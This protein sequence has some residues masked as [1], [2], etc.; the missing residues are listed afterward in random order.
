[1]VLSSVFETGVGLLNSLALG[2]AL[3]EM[4]RA[5]GFD[6]LHFSD[7]LEGRSEGAVIRAS[8]IAQMNPESIWKRNSHSS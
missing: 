1:M 8:E 3:P 6:T 4:N 7:G 2:D 5:L